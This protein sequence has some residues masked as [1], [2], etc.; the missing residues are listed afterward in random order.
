VQNKAKTGQKWLNNA[1]MTANYLVCNI[2]GQIQIIV[3]YIIMFLTYNQFPDSGMWF[4]G[5]VIHDGSYS[6]RATAPN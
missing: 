5:V 4:D 2:E 3:W 6:H 1:K